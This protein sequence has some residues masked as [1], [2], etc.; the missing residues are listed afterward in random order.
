LTTSSIGLTDVRQTLDY[1]AKTSRDKQCLDEE[2]PTRVARKFDTTMNAKGQV[3]AHADRY[4]NKIRKGDQ[5][6]FHSD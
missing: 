2:K 5:V 3:V 4:Q 1:L 6:H